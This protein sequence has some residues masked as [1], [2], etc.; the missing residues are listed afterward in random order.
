MSSRHYSL[1]DVIR[2]AIN[3]FLVGT[4]TFVLFFPVLIYFLVSLFFDRDR[5]NIHPWISLWAKTILVVCPLM[6]VHVEGE[7]RLKGSGTCVLVANHQSLADIIAVLHLS[8]P[9]KFIAKR[10]IYWIPFLG[11]S[12]SLAGYIPLVRGDQKSRK[13]AAQK[14]R[15]YLERGVSVLFFPEGTRSRD[16]EIQSFKAGA[17]KLATETAATVV[18]I[19]IHGTRDLLP[20]G[21]HVFTHCVEVIVKV[22]E[23]QRPHGKE[24]H[25]VEEFCASVR[26]EMVASLKEIR[27]RRQIDR[28]DL[29][30]PQL[31][32]T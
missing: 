11:W 18:P 1:S 22:G 9:F 12:L 16:G 21:K 15:G 20:K 6:R 32:V 17:F 29:S 24:N 14:A 2:S 31:R 27:A 23:P 7:D 3:W 13:A 28:D 25:A 26:A 10:E 8:H 4:V 5:R 19:V 30:V